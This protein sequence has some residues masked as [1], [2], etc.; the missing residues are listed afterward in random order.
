MIK[1]DFE[2]ATRHEDD[3]SK[4]EV[5]L[6]NETIENIIL[7]YVENYILG[8]DEHIAGKAKLYNL[9]KM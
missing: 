1:I 3:I 2:Y 4:K 8:S 5:I 7:D 9:V 6:D